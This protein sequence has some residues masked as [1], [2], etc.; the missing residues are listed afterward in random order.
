MNPASNLPRPI[1]CSDRTLADAQLYGTTDALTAE[2][3]ALGGHDTGFQYRHGDTPY[4]AAVVEQP[5]FDL[6]SV[7]LD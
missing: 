5:C 3:T 7:R 2:L 6:H 1:D 4:A